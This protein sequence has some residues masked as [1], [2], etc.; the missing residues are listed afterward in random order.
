[1]LV[2]PGDERTIQFIS[3]AV[4]D[5]LTATD[6]LLA[7]DARTQEAEEQSYIRGEMQKMHPAG[8]EFD[9]VRPGRMA[10]DEEATKEWLDNAFPD[11]QKRLP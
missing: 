1:M 7:A 9:P 2:A 5:A 11:S 10:T 4:N 8:P 6:M 3:Q